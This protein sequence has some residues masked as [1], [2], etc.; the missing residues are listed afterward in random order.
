MD[1]GLLVLE[2]T[3]GGPADVAGIRGGDRVVR[4]GRYQVPVGGDVIVAIDGQ[5]VADLE[6]WTI[7]LETQKTI[8]D[9]VQIT[10]LRDGREQVVPVVLAEQPTGR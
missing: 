4:M 6:T 2:V 5:P 3:R 1:A 7:Y 10:V 8:G 9:T